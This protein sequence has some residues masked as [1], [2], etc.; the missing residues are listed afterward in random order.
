MRLNMV[1]IGPPGSGKGTQAVRLAGRYGVPHISTGDILRAAVRAA[2]PLGQ[3]VSATLA[4]GGL[5]GDDLITDLVRDKDTGRGFVLDGFPRTVAQ[6]HALD[7]LFAPPD[8]AP[9]DPLPHAPLIVVLVAVSDQAIIGRLSRR[10][11]CASCARSGV[12]K[13]SA[14]AVNRMAMRD[15]ERMRCMAIS[16]RESGYQGSAL[17]LDSLKLQTVGIHETEASNGPSRTCNADPDPR[18]GD[19]GDGDRVQR[20][21]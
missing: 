9:E 10:R 17:R 12:V 2:T 11:L 1:L 15:A 7:E 13:A 3:Q 4:S 5:V 16:R 14:L 20:I 21:A 19:P 18:A 8:R 6:A